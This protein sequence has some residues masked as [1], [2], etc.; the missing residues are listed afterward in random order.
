[1]PAPRFALF[2]LVS[3]LL[4][5]PAASAE[6]VVA[7]GK[8]FVWSADRHPGVTRFRS[9]SLRVEVRPERENGLVG[10]KLTV[11]QPGRRAAMLEGDRAGLSFESRITTGRW[12]RAGELYLM[13][14]SYTGGAHCCTHVQ[15][16]VPSA[17]GFDVV[18]LGA[19]DGE[20]LAERPSDIDGDG[21]VDFVVTDDSFL[22]AFTSYAESV[23]PPKFLNVVG[24]RVVDVST[25][26]AFR[27]RFERLRARLARSCSRRRPGQG[28]NGACAA[29]VAA[30]ARVGKFD[31]AWADMLV[32]YDQ[33]GDSPVWLPTGCRV[34][35]DGAECP[36]AETIRY[37]TF[38]EALRAF[39]IRQGYIA[40]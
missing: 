28:S 11:S 23:P 34:A 39:L 7:P 29:Y 17:G 5:A 40:R 10:P 25:K 31:A 20:R 14:E 12:N 33:K 4:A 35:T 13:L 19:Y 18:D 24:G 32:A 26:P 1:M 6:K 37:A 27:P 3:G 21:A 2:L 22:Y 30:A 36:E 16:V 38:P 15:V 9:G 8:I